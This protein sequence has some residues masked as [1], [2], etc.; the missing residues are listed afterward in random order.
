MPLRLS[1]NICDSVG[2]LAF[3]YAVGII[4]FALPNDAHHGDD[5]SG[6]AMVVVLVQT[7]C[8]ARGN[9]TNPFSILGPFGRVDEFHLL[10]LWLEKLGVS[11]CMHL[12]GES[13]W[14]W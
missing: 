13:A 11:A 5:C 3:C 12:E 2:M 9:M 7:R 6:D 10:V 14:M 1:G 4:C 8:H